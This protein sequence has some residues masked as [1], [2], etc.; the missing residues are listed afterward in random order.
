MTTTNTT[1][2]STTTIADVA[3]ENL[4]HWEDMLVI[5]QRNM[6]NS[7][8]GSQEHHEFYLECKAIHKEIKHA[9]K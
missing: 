8:L 3:A 7:L 9:M 5:A 6:R 1:T 4:E 2:T